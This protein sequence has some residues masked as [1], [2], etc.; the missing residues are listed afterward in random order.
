LYALA[1]VV[2][3]TGKAASTV[4]IPPLGLVRAAAPVVGVI[5]VILRSKVDIGPKNWTFRPISI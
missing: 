3:E 1:T 4:T 5:L 2:S